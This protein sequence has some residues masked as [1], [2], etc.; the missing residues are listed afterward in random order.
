MTAEGALRAPLGM[1]AEG[2][3]RA[4]RDDR[5]GRGADPAVPARSPFGSAFRRSYATRSV[6][7]EGAERRDYSPV[8]ECD[9]ATGFDCDEPC[10]RSQ[11]ERSTSTPTDMNSLCQFWN[12]SNQNWLVAM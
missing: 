9:A 2:A 8:S 4:P 7:N 5:R 12:D 11:I 1:T 6:P 10:S 3:L